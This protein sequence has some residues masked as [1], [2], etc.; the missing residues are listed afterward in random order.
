MNFKPNSA[1]S[2]KCTIRGFVLAPILTTTS[3]CFAPIVL[4]KSGLGAGS[5]TAARADAP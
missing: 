3:V 1:F 2:Y 5:I 4:K